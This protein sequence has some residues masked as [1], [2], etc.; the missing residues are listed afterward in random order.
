MKKERYNFCIRLDVILFVLLK[1]PGL[2]LLLGLQCKCILTNRSKA[3]IVFQF[4]RFENIKCD[5]ALIAGVK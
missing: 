1:T 2:Y 4:Y 5:R 3:F